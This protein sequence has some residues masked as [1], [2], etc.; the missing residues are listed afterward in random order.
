VE[1]FEGLVDLFKNPPLQQIWAIDY[2]EPS[3]FFE[4]VCY[5]IQRHGDKGLNFLLD[6]LDFA[7]TDRLFGIMLGLSAG[8]SP[9]F[10]EL[11]IHLLHAPDPLLVM[12][13]MDGLR[14]TTSGEDVDLILT[15]QHHESAYVRASV[16]RYMGRFYPDRAYPMAI[17]ALHDPHSIVRQQGADLLDEMPLDGTHQA[18]AITFLRPLLNDADEDVRQ[19]ADTAIRNLTDRLGN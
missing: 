16:L 4:D 17:A 19:A 5:E 9:K 12:S 1:S 6:Q 3:A 15:Y 14:H 8:K 10:R 13:V 11:F 18:E 2:L 7:D